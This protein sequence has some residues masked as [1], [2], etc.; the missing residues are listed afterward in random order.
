M[1]SVSHSWKASD[2]NWLF[3]PFLYMTKSWS[4]SVCF[5][6][7]VT[8]QSESSATWTWGCEWS[9]VFLQGPAADQAGAA[10]CRHSPRAAGLPLCSSTLFG[11]LCSQKSNNFPPTVHLPPS[12]P[13]CY[14][15][16]LR[17]LLVLCCCSTCP[18]WTSPAR[19][20]PLSLERWEVQGNTCSWRAW[21]CHPGPWGLSWS[22]GCWC[23][24]CSWDPVQRSSGESC[25]VGWSLGVWPPAPRSEWGSWTSTDSCLESSGFHLLQ[26]EACCPCRPQ[27]SGPSVWRGPTWENKA[28]V[29][30]AGRNTKLYLIC[31]L[32]VSLFM[33]VIPFCDREK[34]EILISYEQ[35]QNHP[36]IQV[37]LFSIGA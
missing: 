29:V 7:V 25:L 30:L 16:V 26:T 6:E 19:W 18:G 11:K 37:S 36:R 15:W 2:K 8:S 4:S 27:L 20:L 13:P 21:A 14:H 32:A 17:T 12:R 23:H 35:N 28:E 33:H 10:L 3:L 24:T 31:L 34:L 22:A 5:S 1:Y 9:R